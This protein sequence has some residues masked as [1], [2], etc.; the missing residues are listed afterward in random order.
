M[1]LEKRQFAN[2]FIKL[3][4]SNN[5]QHFNARKKYSLSISALILSDIGAKA[6]IV[7]V[8]VCV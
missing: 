7:T 8:G 3:P 4:V 5:S 2:C 1:L 6:R